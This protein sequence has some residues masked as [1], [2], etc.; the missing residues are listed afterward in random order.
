[1]VELSHL[2]S[3]RIF[4]VTGLAAFFISAFRLVSD[5]DLRGSIRSA[6]KYLCRQ[7]GEAHV[8]LVKHS[9]LRY[10]SASREH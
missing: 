1:M 3:I 6:L 7:C 9:Y 5:K 4:F 8:A 2:G 10:F